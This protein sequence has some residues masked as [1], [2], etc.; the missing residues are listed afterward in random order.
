M[1]DEAELTLLMREL[2]ESRRHAMPS[3]TSL[4]MTHDEFNMTARINTLINHKGLDVIVARRVLEPRSEM[5]LP[6]RDQL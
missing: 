2:E 6:E 1:L 5:P 4:N 3:N